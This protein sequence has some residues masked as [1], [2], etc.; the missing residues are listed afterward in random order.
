MEIRFKRLDKVPLLR[1]V[2]SSHGQWFRELWLFFQQRFF[3]V[4]EVDKKSREKERKKI[5]KLSLLNSEAAKEKSRRLI[6]YCKNILRW[7]GFR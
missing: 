7:N 4:D 2:H 1:D 3:F 6:N 5:K